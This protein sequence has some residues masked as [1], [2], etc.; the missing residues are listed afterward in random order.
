M[1]RCEIV[2][3]AEQLIPQMAAIERACF[4]LPW[5][6]SKVRDE[7]N[8]EHSLYLAAVVNDTLYGYA[9]AQLI[10]DEGYI[11]NIAVHP[12]HRRKGV[13]DLLLKAL[14]GQSRRQGVRFLTLEVR[15]S[16]LS[17]QSL[18]EKNGFAVVGI[19]PGYY[20]KPQEDAVLYTLFSD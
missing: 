1:A 8:G 9:G 4:S 2:P 17:A 18:Y 12:E 5:S 10:L 7:L 20:E 19:R 6:E 15:R 16:N 11:T 14:I 3:L 13:A